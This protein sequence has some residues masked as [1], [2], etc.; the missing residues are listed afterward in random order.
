MNSAG[1]V[2]RIHSVLLGILRHQKAEGKMSIERYLYMIDGF[3]KSSFAHLFPLQCVSSTPGVTLIK[4]NQSSQPTMGASVGGVGKSGSGPLGGF[5]NLTIGDRVQRRGWLTNHHVTVSQSWTNDKSRESRFGHGSPECRSIVSAAMQ[6]PAQADLIATRYEQLKTRNEIKGVVRGLSR[7][8][9]H[10]A[11]GGRAWVPND[12][13]IL[14]RRKEGL[15]K[16]A[17]MRALTGAMPLPLGTVFYSSGNLTA[18]IGTSGTLAPDSN[19]ILDWSFVELPDSSWSRSLQ[20]HS[21][22]AS[23]AAFENR[24]SRDY[25]IVAGSYEIEDDQTKPTAFG[26]IEKDNWYFKVGRTT[27][28]TTGVCHGVAID[29]PFDEEATRFRPDGQEVPK[30]DLLRYKRRNDKTKDPGRTAPL[31]PGTPGR[32]RA[33]IILSQFTDKVTKTTISARFSQPGDSGSFVFDN[34]DRVCGL[35]FGHINKD[36]GG[37]FEHQC[38]EDAALESKLDGDPEALRKYRA[39]LVTNKGMVCDSMITYDASLMTSMDSVV[40]FIEAKTRGRLSLL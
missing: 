37:L 10:A 36:I 8:K 15:A 30:S 27:G 35:L 31:L 7:R 39:N 24:Q 34:E 26:T 29:H 25:G 20:N 32:S 21:P 19:E 22:S 33:Y 16:Q 13:L 2:L 17:T 40:K 28:I 5:V 11:L 23:S 12:E 6:Y 18:A 9:F 1:A 38:E 4:Q 3:R 14:G